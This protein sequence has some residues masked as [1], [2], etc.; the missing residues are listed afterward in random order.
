MLFFGPIRFASNENSSELFFKEG[1]RTSSA[2]S[3]Y[4]NPK[5]VSR[6]EEE[7]AKSISWLD[8]RQ[9][10]SSATFLLFCLLYRGNNENQDSLMM[11]KHYNSMYIRFSGLKRRGKYNEAKNTMCGLRGRRVKARGTAAD[12][13][14]VAAADEDLAQ[15]GQKATCEPS[16]ESSICKLLSTLNFFS[17]SLYRTDSTSSLYGLSLLHRA[18]SAAWHTQQCTLFLLTGISPTPTFFGPTNWPAVA[19]ILENLRRKKG[20]CSSSSKKKT[21]KAFLHSGGANISSFAAAGEAEN[22]S[23]LFTVTLSWSRSG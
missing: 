15:Q 16:K 20:H 12:S 2:K 1:T 22:A 19:Q 4:Y 3:H 17:S 23:E 8:T 14:V 18:V 10:E 6:L 21:S 13:V 7:V 5:E 9:P 11:I